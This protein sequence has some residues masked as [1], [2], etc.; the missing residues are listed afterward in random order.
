MTNTTCQ[1][2]IVS[3]IKTCLAIDQIGV[4]AYSLMAKNAEL[5]ELEPLFLTM[6][7]EEK[8]HVAAWKYL[9]PLAESGAVPVLFDN[10]PELLEE[11]SQCNNLLREEVGKIDWIDSPYVALLLA[12]RLEVSMLNPAFETLFTYLAILAPEKKIDYDTHLQRL[13]DV[14]LMPQ[15]ERELKLFAET[16]HMLWLQTKSLANRNHFDSLTRVLN[17]AGMM[18]A[19]ETTA[20]LM[21]RMQ[22]ACGVLMIDA[23]HFKRVNDTHGHKKGDDVLVD[24]TKAITRAVRH[25]DLVGRLGGEEFVVFLPE[26]DAEGTA[27]VAEKIRS[28][29]ESSHPG[30]LDVTVSIGGVG[31]VGGEIGLD[32]PAAIQTMLK[33]ADDC[34]YRAKG[35]GRN[36]CCVA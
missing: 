4:R 17:R 33:Q 10:L 32:P 14:M 23:D 16:I 19:M 12:Y 13:M 8:T 28:E 20:F 25:S 29:V 15:R 9:L 5:S 26:V 22:K 2:G 11:M 3:L 21:Q 35:S 34:L 6:A 30:G 31:G 36:R 18:K 24:V 27:L 7:E 1:E